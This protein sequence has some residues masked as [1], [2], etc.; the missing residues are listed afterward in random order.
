MYGQNA[1]RFQLPAIIKID[2]DFIHD[3]NEE[4]DRRGR[5]EKIWTGQKWSRKNHLK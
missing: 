2:I 3:G 5:K 4:K 1:R